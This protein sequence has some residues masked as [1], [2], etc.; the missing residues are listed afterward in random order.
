MLDRFSVTR[1]K[2]GEFSWAAAS[3]RTPARGTL[4]GSSIRAS[5]AF[6]RRDEATGQEHGN[7]RDA[8]AERERAI[9]EMREPR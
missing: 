3:V 2:V 8:G 9:R 7:E 4:R 1:V 5:G 6:G